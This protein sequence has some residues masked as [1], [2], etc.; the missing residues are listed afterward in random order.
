M[1]VSDRTLGYAFPGAGSAEERRE[2][3]LSM[4]ARVVDHVT[5]ELGA[6][7]VFVPHSTGPTPNLDDR[8][9]AD[10]I[11]RRLRTPDHVLNARGDFTPQELKGLAN[12]LAMTF[13]TRLHFTIDA[14]CGCVPSLL[15]THRRDLRCHGIVGDMLGQA[16]HV[17]NIEEAE[18]ASLVTTISRLWA[19]KDSVRRDLEARMPQVVADARRH[20]R[21]VAELLA[22]RGGAG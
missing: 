8:L 3:A 20:G 1:A 5:A 14:L 17:R 10:E 16:E 2:K 22:A 4:M 7:V 11:I 6:T 19:E 9:V 21:R 18:E 12:R 13:G 15:V